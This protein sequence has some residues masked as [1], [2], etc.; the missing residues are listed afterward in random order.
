MVNIR[1]PSFVEID[2]N[3]T[4]SSGFKRTG[5]GNV[6]EELTLFTSGSLPASETTITLE[7]VV[8][9]V[10]GTAIETVIERTL[11]RR[12]FARQNE[13]REKNV[14]DFALSDLQTALSFVNR[15]PTVPVKTCKEYYH[16]E[17]FLAIWKHLT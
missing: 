2:H 14:D 6:F 3:S 5:V 10:A 7:F 17:L 13:T 16:Q 4:C 12:F 9:D 8:F 11:G 15:I 1:N